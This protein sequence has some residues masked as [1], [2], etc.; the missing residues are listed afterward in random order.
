MDPAPDEI[1]NM[2]TMK[3]VMDWAG[4]TGDDLTSDKSVRGTL[5]LLLGVTDTTAPRALALVDDADA[6]A[7]IGKWKVPRQETDGSYTYHSPTIAHSGQAKLVFRACKVICG[8]GQ[9]LE[10]LQKK[11]KAAGAQAQASATPA[12]TSSADERKI[13]LSAILPQVDDSEAKVL[14]EKDLVAAYLRYATDGERPPKESEPTLEQL[15]AI[16]HLITQ[17]NPPYCDFAIWGPYGHRLAKKLKLSGYIIGRDGVLTSVEVTGPTGIGMWLQSWQV[18]SNVCVMLDII[19]LGTLTKYR[20]LV[21]RFHNRY[22]S[23]IW[24][25][26][27]QADTRFRLEMVERIRRQI[28]VE[29]EALRVAHAGASGNPPKVPGCDARRPWNLAYQGGSTWNRIGVKRS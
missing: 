21:E 23:P 5:A 27:Y 10:D 14:R 20:D 7:V 9:T 29:E 22:G 1:A 3:A 17:N 11:L 8:Q 13:K 28:E 26:L 25:L 6:Q 12:A 19:D 18:F 4:F 2:Q 15:S 16:H 24:A